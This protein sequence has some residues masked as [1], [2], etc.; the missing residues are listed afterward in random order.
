VINVTVEF[1]GGPKFDWEFEDGADVYELKQRVA[2]TPDSPM[3]G[4]EV[5]RMRI[6]AQGAELTDGT[7]LVN[8]ERYFPVL[9]LG[10]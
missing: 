2:A 6:A 1:Q 5:D 3:A 9:K 8:G 7:R 4:K 10:A